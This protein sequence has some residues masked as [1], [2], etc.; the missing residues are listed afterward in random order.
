[1]E[2]AARLKAARGARGMTRPG[3]STA[4]ELARDHV[5]LIEVGAVGE[6]TERTRVRLAEAL[7]IAGSE[8]NW[9][10][11]GIGDRPEWAEERKAS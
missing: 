11:F 5:R 3:L 10:V 7:C 1:M 2:F 9:F 4:A 6:P 8:R